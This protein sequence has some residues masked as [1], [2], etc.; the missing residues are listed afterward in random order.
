MELAIAIKAMKGT[1]MGSNALKPISMLLKPSPL[2][3]A[4]KYMPPSGASISTLLILFPL[5][6]LW[7]GTQ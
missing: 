3:N 5:V 4:L 7:L 6:P 1:T 2:A